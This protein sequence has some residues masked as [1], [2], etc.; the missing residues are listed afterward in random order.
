MVL[1]GYTYPL[2]ADGLRHERSHMSEQ[3]WKD[4]KNQHESINILLHV[5]SY[6]EYENISNKD[7]S[8]SKFDSLKR[9][10]EVNKKMEKSKALDSI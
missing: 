3:Q 8:K 10:H 9:Y 7:S 6:S 5:I 1:N 4:H 2:D